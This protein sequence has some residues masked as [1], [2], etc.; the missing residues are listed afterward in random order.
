[1]KNKA[2]EYLRDYLKHPTMLNESYLEK[3]KNIKNIFFK[4]HFLV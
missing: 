1:M 3:V 2:L 4:Y